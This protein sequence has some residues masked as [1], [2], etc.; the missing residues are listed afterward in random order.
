MKELKALSVKEPFASQ[1]ASGVKRIENR[2]WGSGFA[3]DVA[4]HRCG[5]NG[6]ILGVMHVSE[7]LPWVDA[8]AKFPE[9]DEFIVGPLC[10]VIDSFTPCTPVPAKGKLSLWPCPEISLAETP[11]WQAQPRSLGTST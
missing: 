2:S 7:V 3:G 4:L 1:I 5:K 9:Q 10:W 11:A 6:A 8:L